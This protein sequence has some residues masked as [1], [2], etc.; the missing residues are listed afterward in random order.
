MR[1]KCTTIP[2][3]DA[4]LL[5]GRPD[6]SDGFVYRGWALEVRGIG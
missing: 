6:I 4:G 5:P 3:V 2:T 1:D